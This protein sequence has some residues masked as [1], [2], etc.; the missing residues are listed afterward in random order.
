MQT[1]DLALTG[2]HLVLSLERLDSFLASVL[3]GTI[4]LAVNLDA[5]WRLSTGLVFTG[6]AAL[7]IGIPVNVRVG[8]AHLDQVEERMLRQLR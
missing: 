8:P 4:D 5:N 2:G 1:L 3:P 7:T 6:G